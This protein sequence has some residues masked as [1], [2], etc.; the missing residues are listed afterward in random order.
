VSG[1]KLC[2]IASDSEYEKEA[3]QDHALGPKRVVGKILKLLQERYG[4]GAAVR[5][6]PLRVNDL[7][8]SVALFPDRL[9]AWYPLAEASLEATNLILDPAL[10]LNVNRCNE[11]VFL[12]PSICFECAAHMAFPWIFVTKGFRPSIFNHRNCA[13][14]SF[15][16]VALRPFV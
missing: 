6:V 2:M 5:L 8:S 9:G 10:L 14:N 15:S 11:N 3:M 7:T 12:A 16:L 13:A 1:I 4:V